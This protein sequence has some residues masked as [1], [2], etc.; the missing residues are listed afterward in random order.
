[1]KN[2]FH[3]LVWN[4]LIGTIFI[5]TASSMTV[6]FIA[7]YLQS[8]LKASPLMIGIAIGVSPLFST[9]GGFV[10]GYLT[11]RFGRKVVLITT[12]LLWSGVFVGFGV[13]SSIEAFIVLSALNGLSRAFFEPSTQ[14]LMID[15]TQQELRRRMF[16]F[17]YTA[18]N[19]AAVIGPLIGVYISQIS[20][21]T[22]PFLVTACMYFFYGLFLLYIL[23]RYEMRQVMLSSKSNISQMFG[24]VL[25]DKRLLFLIFGGIFITFGYSQYDSTLPQ[26]VNMTI[27]DGVKLY[28]V[29]IAVN[30]GVVLA[31]Q[32]PISILSERLSTKITM[33]LGLSLQSAGL[34][35][36]GLSTNSWGFIVGMVVFTIGEILI[37]PLSGV[38]I[39]QIAPD[40]KKG[41]Y[42]GASQFK[43]VGSFVGPIF[44]G[45]LLVE[46]GGPGMFVIVA[47]ISIISVVFYRSVFIMN[48][49]E[50]NIKEQ[51]VT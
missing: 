20:S 2:T 46:I 10:G 32:L 51:S 21:P 47:V 19:I 3:P 49:K 5:R 31:L 37:V 14:A 35:V 29:L 43:T 24:T 42:M 9:V 36:F 41:T 50:I 1:M 34:V 7:I 39:D 4:L 15:F 38:L 44:G 27:E 40:D 11:D 26:F 13:V 33:Y 25:S 45:W 28:S 12:M 8:E 18:I 30:A 16:S 17:R 22:I 48:Q 6:P 23:N